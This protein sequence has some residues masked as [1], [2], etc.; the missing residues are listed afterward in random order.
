MKETIVL[1]FLEIWPIFK[2]WLG[3]K[4][5]SLIASQISAKDEKWKFSTTF[6]TQF[7]KIRV[8][9][10][11]YF[12]RLFFTRVFRA[13][14]FR[15]ICVQYSGFTRKKT[16]SCNAAIP[17]ACTVNYHLFKHLPT[18]ETIS[19]MGTSFRRITISGIVWV[20][21]SVTYDWSIV[22][23]ATINQL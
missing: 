14:I 9:L 6:Y 16:H 21:L 5:S 7:P 13:C 1:F 17:V 22:F 4:R 19:G 20:D 8:Y 12:L 10:L 11:V 18:P 23:K 15:V 3:G 2:A